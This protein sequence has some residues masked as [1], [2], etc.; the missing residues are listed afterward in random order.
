[1]TYTS[2]VISAPHFRLQHTHQYI[3]YTAKLL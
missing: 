1:M 2:K 3:I